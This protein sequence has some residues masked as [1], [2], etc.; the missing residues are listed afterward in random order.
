[1]NAAQSLFCGLLLLSAGCLTPPGDLGAVGES[2]GGV[3]P[4]SGESTD[5]ETQTGEVGTSG[6]ETSTGTASGEESTGEPIEPPP[7]GVGSG[8]QRRLTSTQVEHA[9]A[10]LFGVTVE[11]QFDDAS[12]PFESAVSLSSADAMSLVTVAATVADAFAVP[13]C[14]GDEATC[15]QEFMDTY[16]PLVLRGQG[17]VDAFTPIYDEVGDH[18]AG[19]RAVV[20]ALIT[21]PA[22]IDLTPTGTDEDG[23][24]TLDANSLATRLA[25]LVWNSVP[26]ADLLESGEGL[27]QPGGVEAQLASML[28]DPRY[29]R[30]QADLYSTMT[31]VRGLPSAD[32]STVYPDWSGAIGASMVEEQR[33]FVA[34]HVGDA[35]ASLEDL[36]TS[37]ST[38]VNADLASLYGADLQTPAPAGSGWGPGELDPTRRAG[39]L[40]Q[41]GMITAGSYDLPEDVF[42][43]PVLRGTSVLSAFFCVD[44]P[45]PPADP[46]PSP[47]GPVES[48]AD[49]EAY[50]SDPACAACHDLSDPFGFAF[51]DYDGVGRWEPLGDATNASHAFLDEEYADALELGAQLASDDEVH[52]CMAERYYTFALRRELDDQDACAVEEYS[53]AFTEG[54]GNLRALVQAIATSDAF[55]IARP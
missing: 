16:V 17:S 6:D 14:A 47:A 22:F 40:T 15:A 4:G 28:D 2:S 8:L 26:D 27:G 21:H 1:M 38:F 25:L 46:N 43:V 41:L 34:D 49:W 39:L 44:V 19:L 37:S 45:P 48:R 30:A 52:A 50:V 53:A 20:G 11:V 18:E 55:R 23:V 29:A 7:C 9:I 24:V 33:R 12:I 36:L 51:G 13:V 3:A 31:G 35:D 54:G 42:R 10:D 5:A 32:R